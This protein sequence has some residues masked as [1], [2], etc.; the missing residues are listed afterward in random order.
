MNLEFMLHC[1]H[2]FGFPKRFLSWIRECITSPKF[3]ICI[4]GTLV[5]YFEGKK[6]LRQGDPI[7][8]YLFVLAIKVFSRIMADLTGGS[9]GFKFHPKCVKMRL[10]LLCFA[11]DLLI[12][13]EASLSSIKVIKVALLE[14]DN[15]FG[16]KANPSKSFFYCSRISD[17]MKHVMLDDLMMKEGHL[18][19]RYLGVPLISSRFSLADCGA[20]LSRISG[21]RL[22]AF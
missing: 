18:L 17:R 14:F 16:L 11:N 10:T 21:Y 22:L 3:S 20:L 1:L 13:S 6:G 9:S 8:P 2:Y 15:L 4:N 5:G 12:F 19:V 7:S